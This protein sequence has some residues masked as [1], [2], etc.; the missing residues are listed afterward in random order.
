MGTDI[1]RCSGLRAAAPVKVGKL[2][3]FGQNSPRFPSDT[4]IGRSSHFVGWGHLVPSSS[5]LSVR[6]LLRE[7]GVYPKLFAEIYSRPS[8]D[9]SDIGEAALVDARDAALGGHSNDEEH[10]GHLWGDV[11]ALLVVAALLAFLTPRGAAAKPA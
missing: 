9:S 6:E 1:M 3:R 8:R 11:P 5:A 10:M 7:S 4:P 2:Y